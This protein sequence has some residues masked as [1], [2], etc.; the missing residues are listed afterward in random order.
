MCRCCQ[1]RLVSTAQVAPCLAYP[2]SV[3]RGPAPSALPPLAWPSRPDRDLWQCIPDI[4][5]GVA[6]LASSGDSIRRGKGLA[7]ELA[8][9]SPPSFPPVGRLERYLDLPYLKSVTIG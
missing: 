9:C 7:L 3:N 2:R 5:I 4:L 8:G 6:R 1:P